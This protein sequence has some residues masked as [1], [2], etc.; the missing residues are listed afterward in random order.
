MYRDEVGVNVGKLFRL[1]D[2][3]RGFTR[4]NNHK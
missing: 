1:M 2:K 4:V 3:I